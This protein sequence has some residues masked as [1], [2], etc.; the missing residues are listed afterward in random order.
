MPVITLD[1]NKS[2]EQNA[3]LYYEKAKKAKKK[4]EGAKE[5]LAESYKKLK[6]L[7][8]EEAKQE[9]AVQEKKKAAD[10]NSSTQVFLHQDI[11]YGPGIHV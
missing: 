10:Q 8:K 3:S 6:K 2:I 4:I 5:A 11:L 9:K 1:I 7:E